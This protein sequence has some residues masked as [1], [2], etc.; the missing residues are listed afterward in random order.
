MGAC[1]AGDPGVDA[2]DCGTAMGAENGR[3]GVPLVGGFIK[4]DDHVLPLPA[5]SII[6]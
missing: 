3:A 2:V 4:F 5:R 1:V 6:A